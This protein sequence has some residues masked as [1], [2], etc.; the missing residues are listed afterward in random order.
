[1][2]SETNDLL[3][4]ESTLVRA[5]GGQRLANYLIDIA[6]FYALFII[7][8]IIIALVSPSTIENLDTDTGGFQLIDRLISLLLYAVYLGFAET[9]L[10]GKT[11]GKLITGTRAVNLDGSKITAST[12][13]SRGFSRAVPF[14]VFSAL[15]SPCNPWQDKWTD[16]MVIDEKKSRV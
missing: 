2:Q 3:N 9:V 8:G 5:T 13:F 1:M 16:T 7:L 6:S 11:L 15:G 12:A 10:K 14:C 4:F